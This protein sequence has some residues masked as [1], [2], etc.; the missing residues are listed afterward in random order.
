MSKA[1]GLKVR[2][3]LHLKSILL[4]DSCIFSVPQFFVVGSILPFQLCQIEKTCS[5]FILNTM[6]QRDVCTNGIYSHN[7]LHWQEVVILPVG[8]SPARNLQLKP[9]HLCRLSVLQ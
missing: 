9:N 7:T 1:K 8:I 3:Y 2:L 6:S 5:P 4:K